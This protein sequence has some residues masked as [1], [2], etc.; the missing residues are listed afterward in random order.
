MQ[1]QV[2]KEMLASLNIP[3]EIEEEVQKEAPEVSCCSMFNNQEYNGGF[4]ACSDCGK[5]DR[6]SQKYAYHLEQKPDFFGHYNHGYSIHK[7]R[8]YQAY[9]NLKDH[10]Y[11]LI[12]YSHA[13]APCEE[14]NSTGYCT[15]RC[16][17][18]NRCKNCYGRHRS[19]VCP[20]P[21]N[22]KVKM[23]KE[24]NWRSEGAY[25][26]LK[27]YLKKNRLS[28]QYKNIFALLYGLGG[29]LPSINPQQYENI[30]RLL[31]TI[32][33]FY[34]DELREQDHKRS[35]GSALMILKYCLDTLGIDYYYEMPMLKT[36]KAQ[37]RVLAFIGRFKKSHIITPQE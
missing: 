37:E 33:N 36:V 31:R 34:C 1:M 14:W 35:L 16:F 5:V 29:P 23:K 12:G 9:T 21:L 6:L 4:M 24:F 15:R 30:V 28:C 3:L 7:K 10:F 27:C 32:Y 17:D 25:E 26:Q 11:R 20:V 8:F 19:L 13:S 2:Y 22:W 18:I